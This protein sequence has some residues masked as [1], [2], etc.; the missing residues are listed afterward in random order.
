MS[1]DRNYCREDEREDSDKDQDESEEEMPRSRTTLHPAFAPHAGAHG[2]ASSPFLP[3]YGPTPKGLATSFNTQYRPQV[4]GNG[5]SSGADGAAGRVPDHDVQ[6]ALAKAS[7]LTAQHLNK[8]V[9]GVENSQEDD[10][11]YFTG[12]GL[13]VGTKFLQWITMLA[14][15]AVMYNAELGPYFALAKGSQQ[16]EE[17][18]VDGDAAAMD[19][20]VYHYIKR[21]CRG[22][23]RHLAESLKG[24]ASGRALVLD[25]SGSFMSNFSGEA[26]AIQRR[27]DEVQFSPDENPQGGILSIQHLYSQL[28]SVQNA[29]GKPPPDENDVCLDIIH[30]LPSGRCYDELKHFEASDPTAPE[31]ASLFSLR[32][33]CTQ[34]FNMWMQNRSATGPQKRTLAAMQEVDDAGLESDDCDVEG[35]VCF[36]GANRNPRQQPQKRIRPSKSFQHQPQHKPGTPNQLPSNSN[37]RRLSNDSRISSQSRQRACLFCRVMRKA[38]KSQGDSANMYHRFSQCPQLSRDLQQALKS[39]EGAVLAATQELQGEPFNG[40]FSEDFIMET[41]GWGDMQAN[42]LD[43]FAAPANNH[44]L[45]RAARQSAQLEDGDIIE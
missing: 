26:K 31:L 21:F 6:A 38:G 41:D 27:M 13:N 9:K 11:K 16:E 35:E 25:F 17:D 2:F 22:P 20:F 30:R 42:G 24:L 28:V 7:I 12:E 1:N 5:A 45:A 15:E 39:Y 36:A 18:L 4:R 19:Q 10:K 40:G 23:A 8:L 3:A 32:I 14:D 43:A 29:R 34:R 44:P 37:S 33:Y